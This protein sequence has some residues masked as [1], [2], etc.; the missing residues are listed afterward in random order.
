MYPKTSLPKEN[1]FLD[2]VPFLLDLDTFNGPYY[3]FFGDGYPSFGPA[4]P[5]AGPRPSLLLE[6]ALSQTIPTS[7]RFPVSV[8]PRLD[9]NSSTS[10]GLELH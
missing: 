7:D 6:L 9:R 2:L 8:Q 1:A 5:R 10:R 4:R 3:N